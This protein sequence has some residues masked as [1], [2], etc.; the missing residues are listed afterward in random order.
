M[1]M[2]PHLL[3]RTGLATLAIACLARAALAA[4]FAIRENSADA[5]GT[6]FAGNASSPTLLSTIFNNPAGMTHF[7]GD[8][9]QLAASVVLPSSQF[10]GG[11][12]AEF[13]SLCPSG[14]ATIL[15]NSGGN[16]G[17]AVF[18]PAGF[19]LHSFSPDFK[20]GLALTEPFGLET[21]YAD[22]WIGRYFG[23][24]SQLQSLDLNPNV[25]YRVN[26]WLS[27][28]AGASAQY[29]SVDLSQAIDFNSFLGVPPG[30]IPDGFFRVDGDD[31]GVGYN[32]GLLFEPTDRTSIGI[33]YRSRVHHTV[34]GE[35]TFDQVPPVVS[36]NSALAP[37]FTSRPA[38]ASL[39]TPDNINLSVM[40]RLTPQLQLAGDLQWTHWSLVKTLSV[41]DSNG[42][43][44][45]APTPEN[46]KNTIFVS[47]GATYNVSESW[48]LRTG[49]AYDQSPVRDAFRTVRL[50]DADRYWLAFGAGYKISNGVS[51]DLGY[52]HIFMPTV[53]ITG[54]VNSTMTSPIS[55]AKDVLTG[56]YSQHI[57]LVSLQTK[58]R[59]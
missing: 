22:G 12:A 13:C 59:F 51:V 25:A 38:K 33:A 3:M 32:F 27:L 4:G 20:V 10:R 6:A 9:A 45:G 54:S 37:A 7:A 41:Q 17:Q 30:G 43:N 24:K 11:G 16:A 50:P 2:I 58:F 44:I 46:F 56:S 36:G 28:G 40:Q 26:Q 35:A 48:T 23:I 1:A 34:E 47:L 5:L 18:V 31:W 55:G 19:V 21:K 14:G 15:G 49:V 39:T 53:G 52:A 8:W 42:T 29:F 57:D